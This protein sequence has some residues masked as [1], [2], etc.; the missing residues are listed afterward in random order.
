MRFVNRNCSY[1][2]ENASTDYKRNRKH[3]TAITTVFSGIQL[4]IALRLVSAFIK[5]LHQEYI[6]YFQK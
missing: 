6:K 2:Y 1:L 4:C 5:N 3:G